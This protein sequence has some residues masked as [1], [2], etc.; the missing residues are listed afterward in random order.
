MSYA[1]PQV[2]VSIDWLKE[3]LKNPS[4]KIIEVDVDPKQYAAGH[5]PGAIGL[6]WAR[7]LQDPVRRDVPS[8]QQIESLL[9][10]RG[11]T[12]RDTIILYGD[13]SNWFAAYAFWV[14]KY[15]GHQD[16]RLLNGGRAKWLN[17][18][19]LPFN[20]DVPAYPSTVYRAQAPDESLRARVI[21]VLDVSRTL[22]AGG[23]RTFNLVDVRSPDEFSG[24]VIAPP[25]MNETAQRAG[26]IPGATS[27]PWGTAVNPDGTFKSPDELRSIYFEAKGLSPSADSVA[28]CRI[29]E[30]SSHTWFVLKYLLGVKN[31]KNYDGS[32]T[33]YGN[34][35]GV[36]I[37]KAV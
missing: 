2:L 15:Y 4:V 32:W 30:R 8:Q 23:V 13:S 24:K 11:V 12:E 28:Y 5:I 35:I 25:G 22:S 34:L 33:E 7:D 37:A 20:S 9:G 3:N 17:D 10:S 1:V 6:D 36:P 21:E 16:V 26:H 18:E 27:I 31:V 19:S 14:L 29:G